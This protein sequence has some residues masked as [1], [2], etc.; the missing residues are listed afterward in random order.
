M[1]TIHL[2]EGKSFQLL[3]PAALAKGIQACVEDIVARNSWSDKAVAKML[4]EH[5]AWGSRDRK[6]ATNIVYS[7]TR[8]YLYFNELC[9]IELNI[10]ENDARSMVNGLVVLGTFTNYPEKVEPTLPPSFFD[11]DGQAILVDKPWLRYS[12]QAW[13]YEVLQNDWGTSTDTLICSLDRPAPIYIRRN[14]LKVHRQAFEKAMM[15]A[16]VPLIVCQ[17]VED[18]YRVEGFNQ[19][20]N[21]RAFREGWMEFQDIG[22]Q[23][24]INRAGITKNMTVVDYCAGKGGKTLHI[25]SLMGDSG[26]LIASDID[27]RRLHQL[28]KRADRAGIKYLEVYQTDELNQ[29][30]IKA[31]LVLVDAPCT[32]SGT[33]R[34]QP[35]LKFRLKRESL[36]EVLPVQR[37][38]LIKA[39]ALVKP[40][41]KLIYAT[42]SV[43]KE[44][45][46]RQTTWFI[47]QLK[48][49]FRL[50]KQDYFV[51][52]QYD[53]DGFYVAMMER[54]V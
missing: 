33:I 29:Q 7:I 42:C 41:G 28:S 13:M 26:R 20:R 53:S 46:E 3:L 44:E 8:N 49:T 17:E 18:A 36:E 32:G 22:S 5:K 23:L 4:S 43:F 50:I 21:S 34:R 24:I 19:L 39:S 48:G 45:D 40:G 47:Q 38:I 52:P 51:P 27:E 31:D 14:R 30:N 9:R 11:I 35:D 25:A 10:P 1:M 2:S 16:G 15:D 54:L 37:E 12:L 6:A